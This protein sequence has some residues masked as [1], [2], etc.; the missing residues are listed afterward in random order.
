MESSGKAPKSAIKLPTKSS[1]GRYF[2]P[3]LESFAAHDVLNE[4]IKNRVSKACDIL[5]AGIP[6]FPNDFRKT[7]HISWVT[8]T[9][10]HMEGPELATQ[11]EVLAIAGRIVSL[12]S[13]G[14]AAF[15]HIM[16]ESGRIQCYAT[17]E[18]LGDEAY[19]L[20]KK[21]DVGDIVGVSGSLFRTKTGELTID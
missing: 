1:H 7:H 14:K 4:V 5:D 8:E 20:V 12:R 17:R 19:A 13:F 2:M 15:F 21:L 6:L 10:A 18:H 16:D 11:E 3:M 9:F